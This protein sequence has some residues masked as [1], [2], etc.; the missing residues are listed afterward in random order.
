MLYRPDGL[1]CYV[2]KGHGKRWLY[3][4]QAARQ[5]CHYNKHLQHIIQGA[6]GVV[7]KRKIWVDL[8]EDD[9]K[10]LEIELIS[11]IGRTVSGGP[12]VNGTD[13][14][15]GQAGRR[16]RLSTRTKISRA[17]SG[18]VQSPE[19]RAMRSKIAKGRPK[20]AEHKAAIG[21]ALKG[22]VFTEEWRQKLRAGSA[23]RWADPANRQKV[24]DWY[25]NLTEEQ[26]IKRSQNISRGMG[27]G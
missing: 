16:T 14:G 10:M 22:R 21:A 7:T 9:A 11:W 4:E 5:G 17:I 19:E 8:T 15:D 18:R 3:H 6:G 25:A 20:S 26:K 1:P 12:L 13:G 2:G 24:Y 23:K 27:Y